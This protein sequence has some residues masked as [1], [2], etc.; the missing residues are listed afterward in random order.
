MKIRG[1][2]IGTPMAK[3]DWNETNPNRA[4]YIFNK[5]GETDLNMGG[6]SITNVGSLHSQSIDVKDLFVIGEG[7]DG[8]TGAGLSPEGYEDGY[9]VLTF[10][11]I[12]GDEYTRLR[13]VAPGKWDCDAATVGQL[14]AAVGNIETA[15][16][17]ILAI[18][19]QLIGGADE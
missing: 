12:E 10:Y 8:E 4:G 14:N 7:E 19:E 18:Q 13:Y 16:D 3:P 1:N 15:L 11:G 5:P 2:T 9:A 6:H 17:G